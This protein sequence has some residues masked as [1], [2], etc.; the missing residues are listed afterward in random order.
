MLRTRIL[1]A[2]VMGPVALL[3]VWVNSL[4]FS[5][6]AAAAAAVMV[7]EWDRMT[8]GRFSLAGQIA[9]VAS[10]VAAVLAP[11][12]P[13]AALGLVWVSTLTTAALSRSGWLAMGSLYVGLPVIALCWVREAGGVETLVWLLL[14]VWATDSGAYFFGRSIGGPKLAPR[15][16]P[17]KT[18]A[19][20]L[21]GMSCAAVVGATAPLWVGGGNP[22]A[23]TAFAAVLA[24]TAQIGDLF[25]SSIKRRFNVKD[26]SRIIPGH[27]GVLDR[28]D[29]LIA[30]APLVALA[31]VAM[32]GGLEIWQ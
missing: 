11:E 15:V 10:A 5:L 1:S 30:A 32:G 28:V 29:G 9:A 2:L 6:L 25:E 19:G 24:V 8:R 13:F 21:G 31:V 22:F 27:G 18:W 4:L 3:A 20:L 16:S 14:V 7:W 12:M 23:L 17:N 26:S